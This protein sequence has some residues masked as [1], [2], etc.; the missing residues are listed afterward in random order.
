[1]A[2]R[3]EERRTVRVAL[4]A[5]WVQGGR[6]RGPGQGR[7]LPAEA[8]V[9]RAP[10]AAGPRYRV[11][12]AHPHID[13]DRR[14]APG[15]RGGRGR[16]P[17]GGSR[18]RRLPILRPR[19]PVRQYDRLGG[20]DRAQADG[21]PGGVPRGAFPATEPGE[22]DALPARPV[23]PAGSAGGGREGGGGP[24]LAGRDRRAGGEDPHLQ[25]PGEPGHGPPDQA[26]PAPAPGGARGRHRRVRRRAARGGA[27]RAARRRRPGWEMTPAGVLRRAAEHLARHGIENPMPTAEILLMAVLR[28]DRA[29]LYTRREG[30]DAREARMFARAI[31][32]RCAGTPL[33]YL[34]GEQAFRGITLEVRPG[35]FIPR[36]ETEVLVSVALA[37]V[38]DVEALELTG[39]NAARL[40]LHVHVL[41]GNLLDPIPNEL[42]GWVDLVVSN[43]PYV[44]P[45]EYDDLPEEVRAEPRLALVGGTDVY[46]DLGASALRWL[47]DG[48]VLAVET[49]A[50]LASWVSE[51][52]SRSF[53][54]VRVERDLAGRDRVVVGRRPWAIRS[55]TRPPPHS[56]ASSSCFR[57]TRCTASGRDPTSRPRPRG[58]SRRKVARGLSSSRSSSPRSP[59][60]VGWGS[61]TSGRSV[62]RADCGPAASR[63]CCAARRR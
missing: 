30:L 44:T 60:R 48:G 33:Q 31:C 11:L 54:R 16:D 10:G 7:L 8:R 18:D 6:A 52:L 43:P 61:S 42:R 20:S 24:T 5:R 14:G 1:R 32:Q 22:G 58:C 13:R 25:L 46:R 28:T 19:R 50:A 51:L 35:V 23:A 17:P 15:G 38:D 53:A 47:R 27:R 57:R 29:G 34:T 21:D 39:S 62:S 3:M 36:P 2:P 49:G 41:E 37:E 59:R 4:G 9:R 45:E 63:W 12:G 55:R 40:G 56:P 26:H